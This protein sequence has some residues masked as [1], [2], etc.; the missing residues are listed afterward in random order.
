MDAIGLPGVRVHRDAYA[1][2]YNMIGVIESI[3]A[4]DEAAVHGS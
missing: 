4:S 3:A 1:A 2:I